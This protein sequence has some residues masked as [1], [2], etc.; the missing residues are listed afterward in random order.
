MSRGS[1]TWQEIVS[2]PETWRAT[3]KD[4]QRVGSG[5]REF[6][7]RLNDRQ[8]VFVGCGSTHYLAQS[9]STCL[10]DVAGIRSRALPSSEVWLYPERIQPKT[11]ALIAVSR[12]GTTTE[13]LRAVRAFR[14][15]G[16]GPIVAVTCYP[17]SELAESSDIV[18][19]AAA[20]QERSI[21]QTRSFT[22]MLLL[23]QVLV[24]AFAA[25]PTGW[26]RLADLPDIL[27][28]LTRRMGDVPA[29]AGR[30]L[31]ICQIVFLGGGPLFGL[32]SEAMLKTI[33]MSL[34]DASAFYPMEIRHG[35]KSLIDGATL[36]VAMLDDRGARCDVD[37]LA[38]LQELG[39]RTMVVAED[40]SRLGC[41]KPEFLI[42][43]RSGLEEWERLPLVLPPL[44]HLA[45]YRA[46]AKGLDPDRPRNLTA[47]VEL[48][49]KGEARP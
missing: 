17:E 23:C 41:L 24:A 32:A 44:Q 49:D 48:H 38:D 42:E 2:Q 9:A 33:E 13:T 14:E 21:A 11:S 12:S 26:S 1:F 45:F 39:A 36:V 37:V 30:D 8:I 3:L 40:A 18:L 25:R 34:T 4:L 43:L 35:P 5:L 15:A 46:I 28:K 20:A 29:R 19:S 27:E 22:S 6:I 31:S 16:G 47:V 7:A 10:S